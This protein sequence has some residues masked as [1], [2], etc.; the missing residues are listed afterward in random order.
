MARAASVTR[1]AAATPR[2]S[3]GKLYTAGER[4]VSSK[5]GPSGDVDLSGY[6]TIPMLSAVEGD[7]KDIKAELGGMQADINAK[8]DANTIYTKSEVDGIISA[9]ELNG[10]P[11]ADG[12][13]AYEI[14]VANGFVG[15]EAA[16]LASLQGAPGA[17]GVACTGADGEYITKIENGVASC[18]PLVTTGDMFTP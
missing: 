2:L 8:A 4:T 13:S 14:A 3:I 12:A 10:I 1:S 7:I 6:A 5:P 17:D 16:W 11:G 18:A 15:T 9:L